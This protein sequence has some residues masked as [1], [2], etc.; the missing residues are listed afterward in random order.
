MFTLGAAPG[1]GGGGEGLMKRGGEW[2][3]GSEPNGFLGQGDS[4]H[5]PKPSSV[6]PKSTDL[7]VDGD[8]TPV[9]RATLQS[10]AWG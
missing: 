10:A 6:H 2:V 5:V 9:A 3:L 1:G 4:A 7:S 8:S